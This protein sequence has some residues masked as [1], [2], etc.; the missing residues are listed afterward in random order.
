MYAVFICVKCKEM[1]KSLDFYKCKK[2]TYLF[3]LFDLVTKAMVFSIL[4]L[5]IIIGLSAAYLFSY[6][7]FKYNKNGSSSISN[8]LW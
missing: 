8:S 1:K 6:N 2:D 7:F 4:E 3:N 5:F